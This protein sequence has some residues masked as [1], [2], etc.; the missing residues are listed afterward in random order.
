MGKTGPGED[1]VDEVDGGAAEAD[2][3][4]ALLD[5]QTDGAV[6]VDPAVKK[7]LPNVS[8]EQMDQVDA[9]N[10]LI[11]VAHGSNPDYRKIAETVIDPLQYGQAIRFADVVLAGLEYL[12][13]LIF[14]YK[15]EAEGGESANPVVSTIDAY[16]FRLGALL[17]E[18]V[19]L[20]KANEEAMAAG[21]PETDFQRVDEALHGKALTF[22]EAFL[23]GEGA[24]GT[25]DD[26][27]R[28]AREMYMALATVHFKRFGGPEV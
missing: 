24:S 17:E 18:Q 13:K 21:K 25:L 2:G 10:W 5:G 12:D 6:A 9:F 28:K 20:D 26:I 22:S 11:T 23:S 7:L 15:A 3:V 4:Y 16:R 1:V 27:S 14:D 19:R 8:P